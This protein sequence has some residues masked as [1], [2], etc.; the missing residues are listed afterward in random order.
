MSTATILSLQVGK[1]AEHGADH[2]SD[3]PWQSGIFKTAVSGRVWLDPLNL[4]GDGQD[5]LKNHGGLFRA[6]LA[7]SADHYPKWREALGVDMQYGAFGENFTVSEVDE[8]T[9][10]LGDVI[11]VGEARL[12]VSQPRL[13][14]WKLARRNGI[15][16]LADYVDKLNRGGWYHRVLRTGYVEAGNSYE[17]LE[18]PYPEFTIARVVDLMH[19][20][21]INPD[22]WRQLGSIE[23][24]TLRWRMRFNGKA[25][26][27]NT[28]E[29]G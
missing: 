4:V 19:E 29:T 16:E 11:A 12:Q 14:C 3:K 22:A 8:K 17:I 26:T 27:A 28:P 5:D 9:V 24:L 18:R 20:R 25:D 6:V 10:C 2:I 15:K 13:P 1:P 7:Y 21:E 23:A